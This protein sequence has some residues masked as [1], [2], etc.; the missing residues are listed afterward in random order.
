MKV[1]PMLLSLFLVLT[2]YVQV[3]I[4]VA[5]TQEYL[6]KNGI[7]ATIDGYRPSCPG[8]IRFGIDDLYVY[9]RMHV[10]KEKLYLMDKGRF[11]FEF[12]GSRF[13]GPCT[14]Y[15]SE[16]NIYCSYKQE[17]KV[18]CDKNIMPP[19]R[20]CWC[21]DTTPKQWL[22]RI[23]YN[24]FERD[25]MA[26][27]FIFDPEPNMETHADRAPFEKNNTIYIPDLIARGHIV[28]PKTQS[29]STNESWSMSPDLLLE[30]MSV[31]LVFCTFRFP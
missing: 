30:M 23:K 24:F 21:N 20:P 16:W 31:V 8:C 11:Y 1:A 3:I 19:H 27:R 10:P 17:L 25:D 18:G 26:V 28:K 22:V 14:N 6:S 13:D 29:R 7:I 4:L 2:E 5:T 15:K 9:G 12:C